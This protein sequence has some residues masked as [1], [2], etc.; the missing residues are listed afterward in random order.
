MP[1]TC[2]WKGATILSIGSLSKAKWSPVQ[3]CTYVVGVRLPSNRAYKLTNLAQS[4]QIT[5]VL[6]SEH[7]TTLTQYYSTLLILCNILPKKQDQPCWEPPRSRWHRP[8]WGFAGPTSSGWPPRLPVSSNPF[9]RR[10]DPFAGNRIL[11]PPLSGARRCRQERDGSS[12]RR[13]GRRP[14]NEE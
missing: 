12:P 4:A 6:H 3:R 9:L 14:W 2:Y 13:W 10:V 1:V 5:I 11:R 7:T 8:G